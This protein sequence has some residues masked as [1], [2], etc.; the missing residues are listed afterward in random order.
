MGMPLWRSLVT[1]SGR[2]RLILMSVE[3]HEDLRRAYKLP[4]HS[5]RGKEY[6][7]PQ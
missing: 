5:S 1:K 6:K 7:A 2:D 4:I 3:K